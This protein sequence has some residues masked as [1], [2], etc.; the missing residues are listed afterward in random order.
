MEDVMVIFSD[1]IKSL[2][3]Y[4]EVNK[5]KLNTNSYILS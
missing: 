1:D 3:K 4:R 2:K 5:K